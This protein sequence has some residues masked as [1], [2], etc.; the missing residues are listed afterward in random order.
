MQSKFSLPFYCDNCGRLC[1][2]GF[3][4]LHHILQDFVPLKKTTT[5][6]TSRPS[7]E[8][9]FLGLN[10]LDY[11]QNKADLLG[12]IYN[13]LLYQRQCLLSTLDQLEDHQRNYLFVNE[14]LRTR[15]AGGKMPGR[16]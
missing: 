7:Y 12:N 1:D 14:L 3:P 2:W 16:T 4:V 10:P 15:M 13:G 5:R 6:N 8:D 11:Q 9:G